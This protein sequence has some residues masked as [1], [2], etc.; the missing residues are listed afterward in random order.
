[1][2]VAVVGLGIQGRKRLAI[3]G[4]DVALT[5]DPVAPDAQFKVV[6]DVPLAQFDAA[7]VCTPD[8][9]KLPLL[10]YLLSKLIYMLVHSQHL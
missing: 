4:D 6:E 2:R 9:N 8:Q 10:N 1:M 3:A 5:V 7:L